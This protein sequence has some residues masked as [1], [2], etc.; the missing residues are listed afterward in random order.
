MAGPITSIVVADNY[1]YA[2]SGGSLYLSEGGS[3]WKKCGS[4]AGRPIT[5]VTEHGP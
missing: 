2:V 5:S 3:P 1:T 4:P